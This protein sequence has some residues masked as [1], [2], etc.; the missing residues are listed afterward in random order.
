MTDV[1]RR[2]QLAPDDFRS[3]RPA[4]RPVYWAA[5]IAF[6]VAVAGGITAADRVR[7]RPE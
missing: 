7:H 5:V 4:N 6:A 3:D 2:E 1:E